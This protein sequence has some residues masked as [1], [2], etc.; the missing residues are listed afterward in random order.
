MMLSSR[1]ND[2]EYNPASIRKMIDGLRYIIS[3]VDEAS[4]PADTYKEKFEHLLG[5][6]INGYAVHSIEEAKRMRRDG[7]KP[8]LFVDKFVPEMVPDLKFI[9]GMVIEK[10]FDMGFHLHT[11]FRNYNLSALSLNSEAE[12]KK[13]KFGDKVTLDC[14]NGILYFDHFDI[15]ENFTLEMQKEEILLNKKL[16]K[17]FVENKDFCSVPQLKFKTNLDSVS[18]DIGYDIGL[19]RTEHLVLANKKQ[20]EAFKQILLQDYNLED[21]IV[22]FRQGLEEDVEKVIRRKS[23][24]SICIRLLDLPANELFS[25]PEDIKIIK[26]KYGYARGVQ[27]AQRKPE[28]YKAQAEAILNQVKNKPEE[29]E[30]KILI[31]TVRNLRELKF[32]KDIIEEAAEELGVNRSDYKFGSMIETLDSCENIKEIA[33]ECDF[34]NIG[35]NDLTSEVWD[36]PRGDAKRI[37]EVCAENRGVNPFFYLSTKVIETA[38]KA[39]K[40]AKE[41]NPDIKVCLCGENIITDDTLIVA[42]KEMGIDSV[43]L[44]PRPKLIYS[45]RLYYNFRYL[46]FVESSK[47]M[48]EKSLKPES[49]LR[50]SGVVPVF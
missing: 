19:V 37:A 47:D 5:E 42:Q 43:S 4:I 9:S 46:D 14:K 21:H 3:E 45:A 38:A 40:E 41:V 27:M 34:L 28:I 22:A 33:A 29:T 15:R 39:V 49:A 16:G 18:R 48:V 13:P 1:F 17:Y 31:P 20:A 44:S 23:N 8:I 36:C 32:A 2:G 6:S 10:K 24:R 30:I 12:F 11:I 7:K 50:E 26:R 25:D 35:A